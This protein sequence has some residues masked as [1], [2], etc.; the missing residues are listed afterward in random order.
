MANQRVTDLDPIVTLPDSGIIHVVDTTNNAQDAA[1]SSFKI[2]KANLLKENTA[3]ILL[4]TNKV[5]ITTAQA[6]AIT[7]NTNKVG[8]TDALVAAAPSVTLNATNILSKA[9]M[10]AG[11]N[12]F[13]KS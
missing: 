2:T 9:G 11:K 8:Y 5:G 10:V 13:D 4:N 3:A 6:T 7:N 1:G 12:K